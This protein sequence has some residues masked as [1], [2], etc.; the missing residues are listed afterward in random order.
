MHS[1]QVSICA[2]K[3]RHELNEAHMAVLKLLRNSGLDLKVSFC[4]KTVF[5]IH[6]RCLKSYKQMLLKKSENKPDMFFY[7]FQSVILAE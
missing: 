7:L 2:A 6:G 5:S 3:Q 1:Q 4:M